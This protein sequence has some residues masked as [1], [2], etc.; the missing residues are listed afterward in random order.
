MIAKTPLLNAS[1]LGYSVVSLRERKT[2]RASCLSAYGLN[3]R[4]ES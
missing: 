4:A 2:D 1:I 3:P